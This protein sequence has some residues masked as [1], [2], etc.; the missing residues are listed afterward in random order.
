LLLLCSFFP[1]FIFS[2]YYLK[3]LSSVKETSI[4]PRDLDRPYS[5]VL[6]QGQLQTGRDVLHHCISFVR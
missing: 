6:G 5:L 1:S 2:A 4:G 3:W